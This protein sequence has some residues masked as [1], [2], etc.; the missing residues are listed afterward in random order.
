M[1]PIPAKQLFRF[2]VEEM[3]I[4]CTAL[5]LPETFITRGRSKFNCLEALA[6]LCRRLAYPCR[7]GDLAI[8]FGRT[9]SAICEIFVQLVKYLHDRFAPMLAGID[10]QRLAPHLSEFAE[11][12]SAKG[13]PLD[14]C[15]G[16]I[17]GTTKRITRPT[18]F[19]RGFCS[20]YKRCHAL[21]FQ[22]IVTPDGLIAHFFGPI[23][24]RRHDLT[25]MRESKLDDIF[26]DPRAQGY[27]IYGD[28]AYPCRRIYDIWV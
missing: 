2:E 24:G 18:L 19:Q 10:W 11:A 3:K 12:I 8:I 5:R 1:L 14:S 17:D 4:I 7:L 20:G 26:L 21:K 27:H 16:S 28:S 9:E 13:A 23:E 6:I 22:S 15:S 25:L